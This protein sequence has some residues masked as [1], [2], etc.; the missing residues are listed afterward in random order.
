MI[1]VLER[2]SQADRRKLKDGVIEVTG[3]AKNRTILGI[4]AGVMKLYPH[5]TFAELKEMLP[6]KLNPKSTNRTTNF[7]N[8]YTDR[9]Y[10][11]V[12]PGSIRDEIAAAN[13]SKQKETGVEE[14]YKMVHFTGEGETFKTADGVEVLV[15]N[16]I[17]DADL[18][19]LISHV[20]QYG[21]RVVDFTPYR[22]GGKKGF[23]KL[24]VL[25][26]VLFEKLQSS[27]KGARKW[28]L[29]A[30]LLLALLLVAG[31]F[32]LRQKD[33]T[34]VIA[35]AAMIEEPYRFVGQVW[36]GAT[37][38]PLPG[39]AISLIA[40]GSNPTSSTDD[41]GKYAVQYM[42]DS[43]KGVMDRAIISFNKKG[44]LTVSDT[45]MFGPGASRLVERSVTMNPY[46]DRP[47]ILPEILYDLNRFDLKPEA[48]DSLDGLYQVLL[49]NP[50]ITIEVRSH[51]DFRP[52]ATFSGG[53]MELSR[54][55]AEAC[56]AYL[57]ERGIDPA[58]LVPVGM[59]ANEPLIPLDSIERAGSAE[60]RERLHA[61]NRRSDFKVV[62]IDT[63][64]TD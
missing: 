31:Y 61:M 19:R 26:P 55:R 16:G 8:P 41:S 1:R 15:A 29:L 24:T 20:A 28:L 60:E 17:E 21:I 54:K 37:G 4:V 25:D 18:Q 32:F 62:R 34:A 5:L 9:P 58:R 3:E 46:E 23:Y 56:V 45:M 33:E 30:L 63:L 11:V 64:A 35:P 59:G 6:D 57:V 43:T 53:N 22:G 42:P 27:P 7:F 10:G 44:Y 13:R 2:L 39:V 48:K 40:S 38:V 52:T 12:Q 51:T 36:D 50:G 47:I 49:D 14:H